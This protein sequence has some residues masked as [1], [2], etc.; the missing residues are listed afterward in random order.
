[1]F[2]RR[3]TRILILCMIL[4]SLLGVNLAAGF[5]SGGT[6]YAL[7]FG[8]YDP[9]AEPMQ[10][11]AGAYH[12]V[13]VS[14][15]GSAYAWGR[16]EQ[17]QLGI[18]YLNQSESIRKIGNLSGI[19]QLGA[20][21]G[22]SV[23]LMND[24][25]V[26]V[27][28][29]NS[30]G[31]IGIKAGGYYSS[32]TQVSVSDI[33]QVAVGYYHV[34][35]LKRDGTVYAW[36]YNYSGELGV[37][38]VQ[39]Y[40]NPV[41]VKDLTGVKYIS[42]GGFSSFAIKRDGTVYAWGRN[43]NGELAL[44]Y[45]GQVTEPK[46]IKDLTGVKQIASSM[47]AS[48]FLKDNGDVYSCGYN[49]DGVLG[50][51]NSTPSIFMALSKMLFDCKIKQLSAGT[52]T[53]LAVSE[54]GTAYGCGNNGSSQLGIPGIS[55]ADK[56]TVIM[57]DNVRQVVAG[58]SF[59]MAL[60]SDGKIKSWGSSSYRQL[61]NNSTYPG[62]VPDYIPDFTYNAPPS[63]LVHT[64]VDQQAV[65]ETSAVTSLRPEISVQQLYGATL[66]CKY[67]IDKEIEP[68]S[69]KVIGN[70][71]SVQRLFLDALDI[72][73][74][75]DGKHQLR[76]EITDGLNIVQKSVEILINRMPIIEDLELTSVEDSVYCAGIASDG[77]TGLVANPYR[78]IL[79]N[80][81]DNTQVAD[82]G[83][84][85]YGVVNIDGTVVEQN[86][87]LSGSPGQR[88]I[89]LNN[90]S[91]IACVRNDGKVYKSTDNGR[92]WVPLLD[93]VYTGQGY[94]ALAKDSKDNIYMVYCPEGSPGNTV[95]KLVK[96]DQNGNKAYD[97]V[98]Y[99]TK[100]TSY[101]IQSVTIAVGKDDSVHTAWNKR[102]YY[103]SSSINELFYAKSV[104]G[105]EGWSEPSQV[106]YYNGN[107]L[108]IDT[109]RI[110][111]KNNGNPLVVYEKN[112]S[113]SK[114]SLVSRA[115]NGTGWDAEKIIFQRNEFIQPYT[116]GIMDDN[117][118]MHLVWVGR[119]VESVT[120]I[121]ILYS[122][123]ED[124]GQS[125]TSPVSI[126]KS[127]GY[128]PNITYDKNNNLYVLCTMNN[129]SGYNQIM[130]VAYT[131]GQWGDVKSLTNSKTGAAYPQVCAYQ[132]N[133]THPLF[134]YQEPSSSKVKIGGNIQ[135]LYIPSVK[136][137]PN[138]KY[139]VEFQAKDKDGKITTVTK[140][141]FTKAKK[142]V[143]SLTDFNS[144]TVSLALDKPYIHQINN[145]A[146]NVDSNNDGVA[147]G[148]ALAKHTGIVAKASLD[149]GV[150][151]IDMTSSI[152]VKENSGKW[153]YL[154]QTI[155]VNPGDELYI[156]A[157]GRTTKGM[158]MRLYLDYS[159]PD[160]YVTS[161]KTDGFYNATFKTLSLKKIIVPANATR[162]Y[163][164]LV[165]D[166]IVK[167]NTGTAW[168]KDVSVVKIN[169][170]DNIIKNSAMYKDTDINGMADVWVYS[171]DDGIEYAPTLKYNLQTI[172]ITS[173]A[174]ANRS[175]GVRIAQTIP[176]VPGDEL[177][178]EVEGKTTKDIITMISIEYFDALGKSLL[179][180]WSDRFFNTEYKTLSLKQC[181]VPQGAVSAKVTYHVIPSVKGVTGYAYFKEARV[182]K[183]RSLGNLLKSSGSTVV[184]NWIKY[185]DSGVG[186]TDAVEGNAR[187]ID[188]NAAAN[189][190]F[191]G[192]SYQPQISVLP[193]EV[194]G[195]QVQAKTTEKVKSKI[196]VDFYNGSEFL[197]S[198]DSDLCSSVDYQVISVKNITVPVNANFM[199]IS[200]TAGADSPGTTGSAWFKDAQLVKLESV[201]LYTPE[202]QIQ[203][204]KKY[205]NAQG[206]LSTVPEWIVLT[207]KKI[208]VTGLTPEKVHTFKVKARNG[209]LI[210]T[211]LSDSISVTTMPKVPQAPQNI[212]A[213]STSSSV[214][215]TWD[216]VPGAEAYQIEVNGVVVED[217][218][219]IVFDT[220][221]TH[222]GLS[223]NVQYNFRVRALNVG[224]PGEW[225]RAT[226]IS[227]LM[228]PPNTPA[229]VNAVTTATSVIVT[230][231]A[232]PN[233]TCY[234][235][236]VD[237]K[238]V[239]TGLET[240]YVYKNLVPY[241]MHT[242]RV[243]ARNTSGAG[244][245]SNLATV[246]AQE[247]VPTVP[248]GMNASASNNSVIVTWTPVLNAKSYNIQ[249]DGKLMES[250]S[251][252][253]FKHTGLL[254]LTTHSYSVQAKNSLG[255][256]VWT[257]VY[258][259]QTKLLDTP[260]VILEPSETGITV[261][262]DAVPNA[263]GYDL[264]VDNVTVP[265]VKNTFYIHSGLTPGTKHTYSVKAKNSSG[266]SAWSGPIWKMTLPVK[267]VRV[268]NLTAVASQTQV[269]LVW[270][271]LNLV[272]GY[273]V[274]LD[275][276]VVGAGKNTKYVDIELKPNTQHIY[277]IRAVN[278][279][280][281]G[282]W[283][284]QVSI[285]TLPDNPK[286]P[287]KIT[288]KG[289]GNIAV[290]SW[291]SEDG[292][293][294][295]DIEVDALYVNGKLT[296][297]EIIE[298]WTETSYLHRK[299]DISKEHKYRIRTRNPVG[300]SSWS[301]YTINNTIPANCTKNKPINLR[302][303]ATELD[304]FSKYTLTVTYNP[305]VLEVMD[306]SLATPK[307]ELSIGKIQGTNIEIKS[308]TPSIITFSVDKI[309]TPGELW[310]GVI[311][312]IQ[313]KAKVSGS[314]TI[315]YLV[316]TA[317]EAE[318]KP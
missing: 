253:T 239:S 235:V 315:N 154:T 258:T 151:R 153:A 215:L 152:N 15:D 268:S 2:F 248:E 114:I 179:K 303:N 26:F 6:V 157:Q 280:I 61:G 131:A 59:S 36:G 281:E 129:I 260:V 85:D 94:N 208:T 127:P 301:G 104:N 109:I 190:G 124:G 27:W 38:T 176:V 198:M 14:K 185:D 47:Y 23:A 209:D 204:G 197:T 126:T 200:M 86:Y 306:L 252:T 9:A 255:T 216:K 313:F 226:S 54:N 1:M 285:A 180:E 187:R 101:Y 55:K 294:G 83:W 217:S 163:V 254:P 102:Y 257:A 160:G 88:L 21:Y 212:K 169:T 105:G 111:F 142:T 8:I 100:S 106:F 99:D 241:S 58:D 288:V 20:G 4:V 7:D 45:S 145:G 174:G 49:A 316:K 75:T 133:F 203:C 164:L 201:D 295:Y 60:M 171:K 277:R 78:Y 119:L 82:S 299:V 90:G 159:G 298:N 31:Q 264:L 113:Y 147:D 234:E 128:Y 261:K 265:D 269:T 122:K 134:M 3:L 304:D 29:D 116:S 228:A 79:R 243:R 93:A 11:A 162:A 67:Y 195:F 80:A 17:G 46:W 76:I 233:A 270:D 69:T 118:I 193:G 132:R 238:V 65:E 227:T 188:V 150:Q 249:V 290:L 211:E 35:A 70:T 51:G 189:T 156:Q 108:T 53:I 110:L 191:A 112:E 205:V 310:S 312:N 136:L 155:V 5:I 192:V 182:N 263:A 22:T 168:F 13:A 19:K 214:T 184:E 146:L 30:Y 89:M 296:Q 39:A 165:L 271:T 199:K 161:Y 56:P 166:P 183:V 289:S 272:E 283:S 143:L 170:Y 213:T 66:T 138:T 44:G 121:S 259:A 74:L 250:G 222:T 130:E 318:E 77:F 221:Y 175:S 25:R 87:S 41:Q 120:P 231:T 210:E 149:K 278:S 236:E 97:K 62:S 256:S 178:P 267:P 279:A 282:D 232:D 57:S 307:R 139:T 123:S 18:G 244:S 158:G 224:G 96:F 98:I 64:P 251:S 50:I 63:L 242:Y 305:G 181:V 308:F 32:P 309:L 71:A 314:T 218:S 287:D 107:V 284:E 148:W 167:G 10:V 103:G 137:M 237:G 317:P 229:N 311:N 293:I 297:G 115:W 40:D 196:H 247:T 202:V 125:W 262:W 16:N 230:W 207:D 37:G 274:E 291:D 246:M 240:K 24:G 194:Y 84:S 219:K 225:P 206:E 92:T 177:V 275:G 172:N 95:V 52:S 81:Y 292:A 300:V 42:A 173:S 302:L 33:V 286:A 223:P 141:I 186:I 68:R 276:V 140:S 34:L 245:W 266:E 12:A 144:D 135:E 28:G 72:R 117:G 220:T 91:L 43:S 273:E 48:F 73:K